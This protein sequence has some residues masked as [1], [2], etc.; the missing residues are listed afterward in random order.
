MSKQKLK[1]QIILAFSDNDKLLAWVYLI[2]KQMKQKLENYCIWKNIRIVFYI[3]N[4]FKM[5]FFLF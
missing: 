1:I 4:T 2:N 5:Q 3:S